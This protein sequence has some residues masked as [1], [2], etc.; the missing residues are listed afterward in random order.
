MLAPGNKIYDSNNDVYHQI[1]LKDFVDISS[2][3]LDLIEDFYSKED[4]EKAEELLTEIKEIN[5]SLSNPDITPEEY[6]ML[7][8]AKKG[9]LSELQESYISLGDYFDIESTDAQEYTTISEHINIMRSCILNNILFTLAKN[10][11]N[12]LKNGSVP[13][14]FLPE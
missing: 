5:K 8:I 1:Y 12:F 14:S 4:R 6:N 7:F 11:V 3:I 9:I 10:P 2:N 13:H